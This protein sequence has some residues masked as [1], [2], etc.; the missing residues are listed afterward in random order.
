MGEIGETGGS[1]ISALFKKLS[2]TRQVTD[3]SAKSTDA[4]QQEVIRQIGQATKGGDPVKGKDVTKS[5]GD[6]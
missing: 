5:G 1:F 3:A 2:F 4:A 6:D